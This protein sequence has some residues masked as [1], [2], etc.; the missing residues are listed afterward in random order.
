MELR[1][2]QSM[3]PEPNDDEA[4]TLLSCKAQE[5]SCMSHESANLQKDSNFKVNLA[6]KQGLVPNSRIMLEQENEQPWQSHQTEGYRKT[7]FV[8]SQEADQTVSDAFRSL[9]KLNLS[10]YQPDDDIKKICDLS[11]DESQK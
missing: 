3:F 10:N 6:L 5:S 9:V 1:P 2:K 7:K 4:I 8:K 11:E